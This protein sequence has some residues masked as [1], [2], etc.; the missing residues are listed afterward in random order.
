MNRN[1][2]LLENKANRQKLVDHIKILEENLQKYPANQKVI[3]AINSAVD[4]LDKGELQGSAT[5]TKKIGELKCYISEMKYF[6]EQKDGYNRCYQIAIEY[7]AN[8]RIPFVV[9]VCNCWCKLATKEG[10]QTTIMMSTKKD[11][12]I[13]SYRLS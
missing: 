7:D 8:M 2:V 4:K 6:R 3:D 9:K 11:M 12:I 1:N 5:P 13:K 10:G